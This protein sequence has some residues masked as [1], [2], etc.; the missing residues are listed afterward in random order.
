MKK[1]FTLISVAILATTALCAQSVQGEKSV[2][3]NIGYQSDAKRALIGA[4]GRYTIADNIRIAP[5]VMFFFPKNHTLGFDVNVNAH[6][7][8]GVTPTFSAYPLAGLAMQ[9]NRFSYKGESA[10]Y[11]DWG[12]NLGAGGSYS[13]NAEN[14]INLEMKY[15][16]GDADCFV[17]AVGYGFKF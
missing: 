10:G 3:A 17:L 1:F 2:V 8:F 9:N 6:Y 15:I 12:F 11:T 13:L 5:D 16:L 4:Q 14:F 7:V